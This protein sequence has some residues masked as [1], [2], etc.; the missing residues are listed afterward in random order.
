MYRV[1]LALL[2]LTG[3]VIGTGQT[4]SAET[5]PSTIVV[6]IPEYEVEQVEG[7]DYVDIPGGDILLADNK[8]RVPLYYVYTDYPAGYRVQEI[9][10]AE[11]SALT[12]ETGLNL[13]VIVMEPDVPV[14]TDEPAVTQG[15]WYPEEEFTWQVMINSDGSSELLLAVYPFYYNP[16]TTESRFYAYYI[17]DIEYVLTDVEI[18]ALKTDR[19][20]Y[21]LGDEVTIDVWL[22]NSGEVQDVVAGVAIKRYGT[23]EMVEGLP[24][25]TLRDISGEGL[26]SATWSSGE[27]AVG[28][29]YVEA[30]VTDTSGNLLDSETT[31]FG[32]QH[33][34]AEDE[35]E[36]EEEKTE[37]PTIYVI[38]IAVVVAVIVLALIVRSRRKA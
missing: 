10:L 22:D 18:T 33:F 25:R 15:G 19:Y 11:R 14:V 6:N 5:P 38:I 12:A 29:Y 2:L 7:Y 36:P 9:V 16:G 27:T 21:N 23:D 17:F 26:Y 24:V 30:N 3:L 20:F 4:I 28:D 34:A 35:E 13:P 31:G 32:I 1:L 37:F 8:P